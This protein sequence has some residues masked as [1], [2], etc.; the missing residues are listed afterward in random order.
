MGLNSAFKGLIDT[1]NSGDRFVIMKAKKLLKFKDLTKEI[2]CMWNVPIITRETENIS[3]S[4]RKNLSNILGKHDSKELKKTATMGTAHITV[5]LI[6]TR[7]YYINTVL[8]NNHTVSE[9]ASN[10]E[11]THLNTEAI[12]FQNIVLIIKYDYDENNSY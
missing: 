6:L 1:A 7:T 11:I 4:L 12:S 8:N 9:T 3:E 5:L 2:R 10:F